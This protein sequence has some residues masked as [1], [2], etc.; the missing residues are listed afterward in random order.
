MIMGSF[1]KMTVHSQNM[2]M[3]GGIFFKE[4]LFGHFGYELPINLIQEDEEQKVLP[5]TTRNKCMA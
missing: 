2:E 5:E 4:K 1:A 3:W